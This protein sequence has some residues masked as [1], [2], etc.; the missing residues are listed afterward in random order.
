MRRWLLKVLLI[1]A[2]AAVI[3]CSQ[4]ACT[5]ADRSTA[6]EDYPYQGPI[7]DENGTQVQPPDWGVQ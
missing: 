3:G 5:S 6:Y 2:A 4:S 1:A 7:M